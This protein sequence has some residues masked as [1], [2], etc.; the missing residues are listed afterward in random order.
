MVHLITPQ[1]T[2]KSSIIQKKERNIWDEFWILIN[3]K[4][5]IGDR[6]YKFS[7]FFVLFLHFHIFM[8]EW[9][10]NDG[11]DLDHQ[12]LVGWA[13]NLFPTTVSFLGFPSTLFWH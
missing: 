11:E 6:P 4:G 3:P 1:L 10:I 2:E 8:E 9:K 5:I 12:D 7:I 13:Y